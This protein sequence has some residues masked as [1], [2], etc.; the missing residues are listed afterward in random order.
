M[1]EK[2][3]LLATSNSPRTSLF[4]GV[5]TVD[6][7]KSEDPCFAK[8]GSP[9]RSLKFTT[10]SDHQFTC[11]DGQCIDIEERCDQVVDCEDASDENLCKMLDIEKNYNKG[12]PP[13]IVEKKSKLMRPA[14]VNISL[15]ITDI[16]DIVEVKHEIEM[17][18]HIL[19]EWFDHRLKFHNLKESLSSNVPT[20]DEIESLWL[21]NVIFS[22]TKNNE[23]TFLTPDTIIAVKREGKV[24]LAKADK[25][26]EVN[27]F[28]GFE[29]RITF[30]QSYAKHFKCEYQLH[31]F[32]FDTQ[33]NIK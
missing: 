5:H 30:Q 2:T 18:F 19:M 31:L 1:F 26:H 24:N 28:D 14:Y 11:D 33:V 15:T 27:I 17:K 25:V 21:P 29:N 3:N 10:C 32:P 7:S 9:I 8:S 20:D 6:F 16:I 22:N 13:F 4:L 12:T 23:A